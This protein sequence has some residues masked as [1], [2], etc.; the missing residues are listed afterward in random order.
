VEVR[1]KFKDRLKTQR[2]TIRIVKPGVYDYGKTTHLWK[3]GDKPV[4]VIQ[5]TDVIVKN[6][7]FR[8]ASEGIVI[9]SRRNV[10]L[11]NVEGSAEDDPLI[12]PETFN[13]LNLIDVSVT[14]S[15]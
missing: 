2:K 13:G 3:G 8:G 9:R 11:L 1:W 6:Y 5:A 14:T 10:T 7:G 15:P 4:M 12:L